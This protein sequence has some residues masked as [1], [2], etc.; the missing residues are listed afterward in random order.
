MPLRSLQEV[1]AEVTRIKQEVDER[2]DQQI[3]L[4]I[5]QHKSVKKR[6]RAGLQVTCRNQL[7]RFDLDIPAK[8]YRGEFDA[9]VTQLHQLRDAAQ[10]THATA[11]L[12]DL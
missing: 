9:L 5:D 2:I 11:N 6:I 12:L 1:A 3:A 8:M 7:V 10:P 4:F